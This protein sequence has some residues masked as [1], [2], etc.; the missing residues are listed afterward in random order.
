MR[1]PEAGM[2][3]R[4]MN[5]TLVFATQRSGSTLLCRD[6]TTLGGLGRAQEHFLPIAQAS[7]RERRMMSESDVIRMLKGG[8][9]REIADTTAVKIMVNYAS[10]VYSCI[11]G[12]NERSTLKSMQGLL[13][14]AICHFERVN[15]ITL[16]RE[17]LLDQAV[18]RAMARLTGVFHIIE[19]PGQPSVQRKHRE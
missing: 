7:K 10:S 18:S 11:S 4:L 16:E 2:N 5:L 19:R 8:R 6:I 14:W 12:N 1:A 3:S 17:S 9:D 13:D 15:L